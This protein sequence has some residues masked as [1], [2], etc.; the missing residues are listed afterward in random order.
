MKKNFLFAS[1]AIYLS[2]V[3]YSTAQVTIGGKNPPKP[4]TILDL[5]SADGIRGG[6]L[7]SHV[8]ITDLKRIPK[9]F[10][11]VT[12]DSVKQ[13]VNHELTGMIVYNTN[14]NLDDGKGLYLWDGDNWCYVGGGLGFSAPVVE[15]T[16]CPGMFVPSV[17]FMPYNLGADATLNTPKKQMEYL[18]TNPFNEK[19]ERVYGGLYQW[20]R[21]DLKHGSRSNVKLIKGQTGSPVDGEFYYERNN[22]YNG[23]SAEALWGNGQLVSYDWKSAAGGAV[24]NGTAYYQKPVKTDNDPCP[25]GWRVPTQDEWERTGFYDCTP[26]KT[27]E[28]VSPSENKYYYE[29]TVSGWI[30]V[31]VKAGK[32]FTGTWA[33]NEDGGWAVYEKT[34]WDA[35]IAQGG[36]FDPQR[37]GKPDFKKLLYVSD[38]PSPLLFLPTAGCRLFS[39]GLVSNTGGSG[40]YWSS[41]ITNGGS[42]YNLSFTNAM[43]DASSVSSRGSGFSIRCVK[44]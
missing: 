41:S 38:A 2:I 44:E 5:N 37:T 25:A 16:H 14:S 12:I 29:A 28:H 1:V 20:G 7:P 26:G 6:L 36:Y 3:S 24:Y 32:P 11:G 8:K 34:V 35:A 39:S 42:S 43:I 22:W 19:D 27:I 18:A 31:R 10:G 15:V 9:I 17:T 30:W 23:S 13:D 40:F 33:N 4:G 21:K